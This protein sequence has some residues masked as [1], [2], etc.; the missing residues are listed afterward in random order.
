[1]A[2]RKIRTPTVKRDP[3]PIDDATQ[4]LMDL[5]MRYAVDRE[6]AFSLAGSCQTSVVPHEGGWK[7]VNLNGTEELLLTGVRMG[8]RGKMI[9]VFKPMDAQPWTHAEFVDDKIN[10]VKGLEPALYELISTRR[11]PMSPDMAM[12]VNFLQAAEVFKV[13]YRTKAE[14][15]ATVKVEAEKKRV[16]HAYA[17]DEEWGEF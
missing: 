5:V 2:P 1:M 16:E 9:F 14:A 7:T 4:A 11:L 6:P 13:E 17:D 8:A 3:I 12:T 10:M 15:D